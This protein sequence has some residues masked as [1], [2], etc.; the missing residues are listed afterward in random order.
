M[1]SS[2][3][4]TA[5]G[6]GSSSRPVYAHGRIVRKRPWL[7]VEEGGILLLRRRQ[8][9]VHPRLSTVSR[10]ITRVRNRY[11]VFSVRIDPPSHVTHETDGANTHLSVPTGIGVK[12]FLN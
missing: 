8:H 6:G 9:M 2:S 10:C 12:Q 3:F 4:Q 1:T 5:C 7:W 11:S